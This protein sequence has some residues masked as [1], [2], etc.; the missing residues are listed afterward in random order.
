MAKK[1]MFSHRHSHIIIIL[2]SV[3]V[4]L[5]I[6]AMVIY[7]PSTHEQLTPTATAQ[8]L[9]NVE[10][11]FVSVAAKVRPAVVNI[12]AERVQKRTIRTMPEIPPELRK[13]FE[14]FPGPFGSPGQEP[15]QEEEIPSRS[16]GS[17]W[18]YRE[19]GYIVTNTHVVKDG[20]NFHVQLFDKDDDHK[21]DAKLIGKDPKDGPKV[22]SETKRKAAVDILRFALGDPSKAEVN[23]TQ[24][25][26]LPGL[27]P[28]ELEAIAKTKGGPRD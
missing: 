22:D 3:L 4:G 5:G 27:G 18:I 28:K 20:A 9:A 12:T 10:D 16:A 15:G 13:F 23:V 1:T 6:A 24:T 19:D 25:N 21:Y 26:A 14:Q 11:A 8:G 17:G 2:L 7:S